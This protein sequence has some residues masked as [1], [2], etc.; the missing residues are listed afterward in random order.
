MNE[1]ECMSLLKMIGGLYKSYL[2]SKGMIY[3]AFDNKNDLHV[4]ES[5]AQISFD[6][7]LGEPVGAIVENKLVPIEK[8]DIS[9]LD[10]NNKLVR[11]LSSIWLIDKQIVMF[12]YDI[13]T[14]F[15]ET[16][17]I[18]IIHELYSGDKSKLSTMT[19][20][21]SLEQGIHDSVKGFL[22]LPSAL[23]LGSTNESYIILEPNNKIKIKTKH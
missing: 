9:G 18:D 1:N 19:L 21:D 8:V 3:I 10:K 6:E 14:Y 23:V 15:I 7:T 16:D 13:I 17:E 2:S 4:S 20:I 5:I 12:V 11:P 22:E